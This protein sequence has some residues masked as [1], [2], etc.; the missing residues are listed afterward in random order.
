MQEVSFL[1]FRGARFTTLYFLPIF[2]VFF[3]YLPT[4]R[5]ATGYVDRYL[6]T[7]RL[8]RPDFQRTGSEC[9]PISGV[10]ARRSATERADGRVGGQAG[11]RAGWRV[12]WRASGQA[13]KREAGGLVR[14]RRGAGGRAGG[15]GK[16]TT[17]RYKTHSF[18]DAKTKISEIQKHNF[19]Y[20][21][22]SPICKT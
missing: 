2:F 1:Y 11:R 3:L 15:Q 4:P 13:G 22:K 20:T 8:E 21:K 18:R 6:D 14:G 16:R 12:G 9:D 17:P 10:G 5:L 19:R 7:P